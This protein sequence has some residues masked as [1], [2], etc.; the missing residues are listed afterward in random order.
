MAAFFIHADDMVKC[1]RT[2][3]RGIAMTPEEQAELGL[4][5]F[6]AYKEFRVRPGP[7]TFDPTGNKRRPTIRYW[8]ARHDRGNP[9][10]DAGT[11]GE[12]KAWID[13]QK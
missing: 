7:T 1:A 9:Q 3:F 12:L 10:K 11:V 13:K 4:N 2:F 8:T 6:F 5:G